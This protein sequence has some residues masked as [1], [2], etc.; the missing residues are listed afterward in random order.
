MYIYQV[1]EMKNNLETY[2]YDTRTKLFEQWEKFT[3]SAEKDQFMELLNGSLNWLE[4]EGGD[5]SLEVYKSRLDPL[6][7][8]GGKYKIR[9]LEAE[10][11]P[12]AIIT[13][14][15]VI[16]TYRDKVL[17]ND[18]AHA[19][20]P[21]DKMDSITNECERIQLITSDLINK[22]NSLSL[23]DDPVVFTADLKERAQ[24]L[25]KFC[26]TVL[27]TPKPQPKPEAKPSTP[28]TQ[29]GQTPPPPTEDK[30]DTDQPPKTPDNMD[31][32]N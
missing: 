3:T 32:S 17:S 4:T 29:T 16:Q 22:Q 7:E 19:H 28:P 11:R 26:E 25:A 27:S 1:S 2:I 15:N 20:I 10:T 5:Q 24:N 6:T 18:V 31:T 9:Y 14:M 21:K 12:E 23:T 30:M 8:I 13:L